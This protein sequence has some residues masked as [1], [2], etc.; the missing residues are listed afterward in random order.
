[1][2]TAEQVQKLL[3]HG[4]A[5]FEAAEA[6]ASKNIHGL[7]HAIREIYQRVYGRVALDIHDWRWQAQALKN[8]IVNEG[9]PKRDPVKPAGSSGEDAAHKP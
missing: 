9:P 2:D 6:V 5:R 7:M 8:H 4:E 3:R 1:M